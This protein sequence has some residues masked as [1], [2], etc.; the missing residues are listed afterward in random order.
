MNTTIKEVFSDL[1]RTLSPSSREYLDRLTARPEVQKVL[2]ADEEEQLGAR[3]AK[4]ALI[5]ATVARFAK[6]IEAAGKRRDTLTRQLREHEQRGAELRAETHAAEVAFSSLDRQCDNAVE[7]LKLEL[8]IDADAR[9][10]DTLGHLTHL[11]H[12]S[13]RH[14]CHSGIASDGETFVTNIEQCNAASDAVRAAITACR[15]MQIEAL[16]GAAVESILSGIFGG[17]AAPLAAIELNAP[18][19]RDGAVLAPAQF[20]FFEPA[21]PMPAA[22]ASI[23]SRAAR[24]ATNTGETLQ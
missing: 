24:S 21:A 9:I 11:L 10:E 5:P 19:I 18:R 22:N 13:I 14:A 3:T 2:R 8:T 15:E 7:R 6:L 16:S 17:L 23:V 1:K 4:V 12:G 20:G